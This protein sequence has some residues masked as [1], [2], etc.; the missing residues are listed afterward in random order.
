MCAV[1]VNGVEAYDPKTGT[2][3]WGNPASTLCNPQYC[4]EP[5][6]AN[7]L[8]YVGGS[9]LPGD[10]GGVLTVLDRYANIVATYGPTSTLPN[11]ITAM[12]VDGT[13]YSISDA[14]GS[15]YLSLH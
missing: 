5:V 14:N 13:V 15:A 7:G 8:L 2:S 12:V 4:G 3:L 6:L 1:Y 9:G 11:D 10:E